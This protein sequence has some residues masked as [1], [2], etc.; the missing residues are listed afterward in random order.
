MTATIVITLD[1]PVDGPTGMGTPT[2]TGRLTATPAPLPSEPMDRIVIIGCGGSGK[3]TVA[4]HLAQI[5]DIPL[6]HLDAVYYDEQWNPLPQDAFAA[7]QAKLVTEDRWIIEGNYASTLPIR[8]QAA[9]TVLFLD[10]PAAV[11]LWG[12]VGRRRRYRGGQH[13]AVGVYDRITWSFVRYI[14]GYRRTMRPRVR[15][16]LADHAR[17]TRLITLTSRGQVALLLD[18]IR[19]GEPPAP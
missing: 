17:H 2:P 14:A 5:L 8:L 13:T 1:G 6:T 3:S 11:C 9:D 7:R 19:V 16:L 12:I 18:R 10:I 4:R 15:R